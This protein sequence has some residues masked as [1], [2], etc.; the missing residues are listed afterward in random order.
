MAQHMD[1]FVDDG[2]RWIKSAIK[3]VRDYWVPSNFDN[4]D[5]P[6]IAQI[7]QSIHE[8]LSLLGSAAARY[9]Q[10]FD[11]GLARDSIDTS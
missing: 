8:V 9:V 5:D 3:I 7:C 1:N 6:F 4:P 11:L 10:S 2:R